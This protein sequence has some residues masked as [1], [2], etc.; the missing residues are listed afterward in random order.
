MLG[1]LCVACLSELIMVLDQPRRVE[2]GAL[3]GIPSSTP[4][5]CHRVGCCATASKQRITP[6]SI[7]YC[8]LLPCQSVH[9][10]RLANSFHALNHHFAF[11]AQP[12]IGGRPLATQRPRHAPAGMLVPCL[13]AFLDRGQRFE[14]RVSYISSLILCLESAACMV[15]HWSSTHMQGHEVLSCSSVDLTYPQCKP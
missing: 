10:R 13:A 3:H 7:L 2:H 12:H 6:E 5:A 9:S 11:W 8:S 15:A 1:Q 4:S 14:L